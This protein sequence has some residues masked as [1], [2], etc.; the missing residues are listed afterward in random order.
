MS[1]GCICLSTILCAVNLIKGRTNPNEFYSTFSDATY[2]HQRDFS[3]HLSYI[4][5]RDHLRII[6]DSKNETHMIIL[7][8]DRVP[9]RYH[10]IEYQLSA[11]ENVIEPSANGKSCHLKT[12]EIK[13]LSEIFIGN[14]TRTVANINWTCPA[15]AW[16]CGAECCQHFYRDPWPILGPDLYGLIGA[17]VIF[18]AILTILK[19]Y[20]WW[21]KTHANGQP[22][23]TNDFMETTKYGEEKLE[24]APFS[25]WSPS[26]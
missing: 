1:Q 18:I 15:Y 2:Q 13:E 7:K 24:V 21:R 22:I 26:L 9:V 17:G 6:G 19:L 14:S 8:S 11:F 20:R 4:K 23:P 3:R 25:V 5:L 16:C 10:D 12:S